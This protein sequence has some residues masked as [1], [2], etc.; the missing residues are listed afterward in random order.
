MEIDKSLEQQMLGAVSRN[1]AIVSNTEE[2]KVERKP[3]IDSLGRSYGTGGR[4]SAKARVWIKPGK[5]RII[6]NNKEI[7]QYFH[8]P[9]LRM[10]L[11]QPFNDTNTLGQFDAYI[12][13]K[14]SGLSGQAGAIRHGISNALSNY[15]P[16]AYHL[17]LKKAGFITRDSRVVER[18][19]YGQK[20]ARK[21]FQFS[22]R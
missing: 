17:I 10:I 11:M 21:R 20:K 3:I 15:N 5:G 13:V 12:T 16:D 14:G 4:K 7:D 18:K 1:K 6:I 9:V 8:R 19:K 22:K 2:V